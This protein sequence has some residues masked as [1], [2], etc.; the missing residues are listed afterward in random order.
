MEPVKTLDIKQP[1]LLLKVLENGLLCVVDAQTTLRLLN[2][3]HYKV[4]GGCKTGLT[5]AV[6]I[7]RQVDVG[8]KAQV[9]AAAVPDSN[10]AALFGV[11]S[12]K[13]LYRVGRHQGPVESVAVDPQLR[14]I[15]TGGQDG[16][17]FA[18]DAKT[19]QLKHALP[20]HTD[21]ITD[22]AFS[23]NARWIA[24]GSFDK[25]IH[26]TEIGTQKTPLKL[27]VHGSAVTKLRF[28]GDDGLLSVEKEGQLI[29]WDFRHTKVR[30]RLQKMNDE[31]TAICVSEDER[32]LFVGTKLGYVAVYDLRTYEILD[33]AYLKE[34]GTVTSLAYIAE[35]ERLAVGLSDGRINFYTLYGD[36]KQLAAMVGRKAFAEFYDALADNTMLYFSKPYERAE[37]MWD[38][39]VAEAKALLEKGNDAAAKQALSDF[40]NVGVKKG[41][42]KKLMHSGKEYMTFKAHVEEKRYALAYAMAAKT[43]DFKESAPYLM[44]EEQ[45]QVLFS[46]ARQLLSHK[47]GEEEAKALFAPY[48]GI[49]EK[50]ALIQDL[51]KNSRLYLY[52]KDLIGKREW[53]KLFELVKQ[54]PFLKEFR[55]YG[56]VLDYADNLFIMVHKA[57]DEGDV[58][59]VKQL[60]E[61]L[62]CFPDY[63][64]DVAHILN[65]LNNRG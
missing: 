52:F 41:I 35:G 20:L 16:K 38:E 49:S 54:H 55:E 17:V 64:E 5:Q 6:T 46:K 4:L 1:V 15:I 44:M 33:N 61:T 22:I 32:F 37:K 50:T 59:A 11:K 63:K 56:T 51:L 27:R 42:I 24:T 13:L 14:F 36:E 23:D 18:W 12:S 3:S 2:T 21:F 19:A 34:Q 53:K 39:K 29:V 57:Q 58:N 47:K 9:C 45:W 7:G 31:I 25:T 30:K 65:E 48:R 40:S 43:P 8:S 60:C 10:K 26:I 62:L 28:I